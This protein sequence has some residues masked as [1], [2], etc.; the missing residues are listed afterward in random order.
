MDSLLEELQKI[1]LNFKKTPNRDYSTKYLTDK[2][3]QII[4]IRTNFS[5][6]IINVKES[7][8]LELKERFNL[9]Y[10]KVH[11]IIQEK[12]D[13]AIDRKPV[14]DDKESKMANNFDIGAAEKA[15]PIF[16]GISTELNKF[17]TMTEI[18][19]DG[20]KD[21]QKNTLMKFVFYGKLSHEVQTLVGNIPKTFEELKNFLTSTYKSTRT[22][23]QVQAMLGDFS[24]K[25]MSVKTYNEKLLKLIAELSDLQINSIPDVT[26]EAKS[27]I[28]NV[29][30]QTALNVFKSG[31][32]SNLKP[33]IYAA[34]P[35]SLTEAV[36]LASEVEIE[37]NKDSKILSF[38]HQK[39]NSHNNTKNK[40]SQNYYNNKNNKN[41]NNKNNKNYNKNYNKNNDDSRGQS[42]GKN[43]H[44]TNNK[45]KNWNK[46]RNI[47][48][49]SEN[50][51]SPEVT[52]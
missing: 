5:L 4:F 38:K 33:T 16:S 6:E 37:V 40:K 13:S 17:L 11:G 48:V 46:N 9:L 2:L 36:Q 43:N 14:K 35:A 3:E 24:Q 42:H 10:S 30:Q 51:V 15:I 22:V 26:E 41:Y 21:D 52:Q 44:Q 25:G 39:Y 34:R 29:N 27:T 23:A 45:N 49:V 50:T 18:I 19:H 7:D 28:K 8:Q 12:L 31:L 47:S 32:N 20:L 1:L